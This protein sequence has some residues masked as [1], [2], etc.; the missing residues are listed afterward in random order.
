MTL[1][2]DIPAD[3]IDALE[4]RLVAEQKRRITENALAHYKPYDRQIDF[5]AAGASHRERLLCA[6][7]SIG[8]NSRGRV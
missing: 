6:A 4:A 2:A 3:R 7:N 5:H 1:A 8:Q